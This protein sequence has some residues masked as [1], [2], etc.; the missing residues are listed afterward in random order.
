MKKLFRKSII[1]NY[2]ILLIFT[3]MLEIVF[4]IISDIKLFDISY[5][6]IFLGL[7]ILSLLLSFIFSWFNKIINK[8]LIIA[9]TLFMSAYAFFQIGF[10]NFIG[11]YASI[12]SSSQLGAVTDYIKDFFGSFLWTYYLAFIPFLILIIYY[13]FLDKY[14]CFKTDKKFPL[15]KFSRFEKTSRILITFI[16]IVGLGFLYNKTLSVS[17]MQN[18]LQL[19]SNKD[20]FNYPSVP[21]I[22]V[23]QFGVLGFGFLDVKSVK[24][25]EPETIYAATSNE[26]NNTSN[27]RNIDDTVWQNVI[28]NETNKARNNISN[29][30]INQPIAGY[31]DYTGKFQGKNLIVIMMESANEILINKDLY[32]N[33]YKIYTEGMSFKNH[34][35]PRNSCS[36]GNNEFSGMTGLYSIQNNCT[37]NRYRNNTYFTSIFN[38]FNNAGYRTSSMHNYTEDY[39]YR[40]TIHKNM[41]SSKYYGVEDLGIEYFTEYKNWSNDVDFIKKAMDITLNNNMDSPFMLW[42]TTVSSHQ[43]YNIDSI[44]GNRYYKLMDSTYPSDLRRYMSKLKTLDNSLGV[45]L[46]RLKTAGILDD[47]VIVLY[48]DHYPYGLKNSTI[49]YALPYDLDDYEVERTPMVIYNSGVESEIIDKY[50]SYVNLTPTLAN[51]FGLDYDPRYYMGSDVLSDDYLDVV[52]FADGSWKN[53]KAFYDASKGSIKYYTDEKM[54]PEE[55]KNINNIINTKMRMSSLIIKDNYFAYLEKQ[56]QK[57][58]GEK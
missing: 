52:V 3:N 11:V 6:R 43:P 8:I 38:L 36:T 23:N 29:Y 19:V 4:R 40:R 16:L 14:T 12:N 15:K 31:N 10:N 45:L 50:S 33:F 51:L 9:S 5:L 39:Y 42:L 57:N 41:G 49:N 18:E 35:S 54:A 25:E 48:G 32:P 26:E 27:E 20:L 13:I 30:L 7:N 37:A 47:T 17:F 46:E 22:V 28:E 56:E 44:E 24:T 34:Y 2:I 58:E 21:S 55:I 1:K 53:S